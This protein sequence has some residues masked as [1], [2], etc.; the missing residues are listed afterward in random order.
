[1]FPITDRRGQVVGYGGRILDQGEP[2][3]LNSPETPFFHK[4]ELLYGYFEH[5]DEI[6]SRKLLVVVE[7]YM[8]VLAMAAHGLPV[9]LAPLGTAIGE[10]QVREIL[11][12][13]PEPV[14]CFDGDRAGRQAAWRALEKM[15]PVLAA[16][17]G[18]R[19]L[20][21]PEGEDPDS[22]LQREGSEAFALRLEQD[23]K[24]VLDTWIDGLRILAGSGP[25][26]RARMAKKADSMLA[27]MADDYLSQAWRQEAE[28][29]TAITLKTPPRAAP[30]TV[31]RRPHP[32]SKVPSLATPNQERFLAALLQNPQ[33]IRGLLADEEKFMLDD[34][35]LNQLYTRVLELAA[36]NYNVAQALL[37]DF[38]QDERI[39]L[40]ASQ[41]DISDDEFEKLQLLMR[42]RYFYR[43]L[44]QDGT[45]AEKQHYRYRWNE[46]RNKLEKVGQ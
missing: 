12:L 28:K 9:G 8:D 31:L 6:R 36:A 16:E 18:P 5:R 13:H 15:L 4:S 39:P 30:E 34:A 42:E 37:L 10:R 46:I 25:E 3:Y 22:L 17:H 43:L 2:K 19:F 7:G 14:F 40:W 21:L 41:S 1:M 29:V 23:A 35:G 26:G 11:R 45:L 24:P 32:I 33:R 20:Y 44:K 38:P 27:A